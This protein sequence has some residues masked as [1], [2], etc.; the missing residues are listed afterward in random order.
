MTGKRSSHIPITQLLVLAL[1]A[2]AILPVACGTLEIGIETVPATGDVASAT[3]TPGKTPAPDDTDI[4][5][6]PA[7]TH[8]LIPPS[9]ELRVAFV[10]AT[11]HGNN[12]WLWT[13]TQG[14]AVPLTKDGGV[15][16]VRMS[17]DGEIVAFTRG[18][19]L[20]IVDSDAARERE[21]VSAE[22]FAATEGKDLALEVAL[23]RFDWIPGTHV[24]A[25][26]TRL[27]TE[28]GQVLNDDLHAFNVDTGQHTALLPPG[29]GGEFTYAPDGGQVAIVTP[30]SISL[31]DA[32]GANRREPLTYTPIATASEVQYY[33][34][35]AWAAD[36]SALR[37]VIPPVDPFAQPSADASVWHIATDGTP[38]RLLR[39]IPMAHTSWPAFS[40]DLRYVAHLYMEQSGPSPR[41]ELLITDLDLDAT[42]TYFPES[43]GDTEATPES[44]DA[45]VYTPMAGEVY[46]WWPGPQPARERRFAFLA[47][48]DPELPFQA[49]IGQLGGELVPVDG[50][51]QA[52]ID[53]RWV[54]AERYL[55]LAQ[56]PKGWDIKLGEFAVPGGGPITTVAGVVGS[57]PA[58]D[59]AAP[60]LDA[61]LSDATPAPAPFA[62]DDN[63][64][65]PFGLV[66]RNAEGLWH[67][68]ADGESV[69]L[70][71]R[72]GAAISPDATQVLY[73]EADDIWLAD[74]ATGERRNVTGT[75]DR[76]DCCP[77]WWPARPDVLLFSSRPPESTEPSYG[78]PTLVQL[79]GSDY[80][81]LDDDDNE[82][83]FTLPAPSPD[84][85]TVAYDRAGQA[86]LYRNDTGPE[87]F[88]LTR[89][90]LASDP[91]LRVVSPAWSPDGRRIAWVI[92]DCRRGECLYGVGV[93]DLELGNVLSLHPY[94][95]VGM[96]GQ[97]PGPAWSPDGQWL[98]F[99]AWATDSQD[100]GLW[101][102]R[103]AG[104]QE[105]HRL[106]AASRAGHNP[107]WSPDGSWLAFTSTT[108]GAGPGPWLADAETW[109]VHAP[110]LPLDA[111][112]VAWVNPPGN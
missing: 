22:A 74:V 101:V 17:D 35:P 88:D 109:S 45:I 5:P 56:S 16:D 98:A 8:T 79:D 60:V 73:P 96:G 63:A 53:V 42:M 3:T 106:D 4:P 31:I 49:Q 112:P 41:S 27:R 77:R 57:R 68:N 95:P 51:V 29:Q 33:A 103:A 75:P 78:F 20:W 66:Y 6:S 54:D 26:N 43:D 111:S 39:N 34:R 76:A 80:R 67:V 38:A 104:S 58:Y 82:A 48:T 23:N 70:F 72:P 28:I 47:Q 36:A 1:L 86:W 32:D 59:F 44:E 99:T 81:V 65:I 55:Y 11:E 46:G 94:T 50:G 61:P 18:D 102:V 40:P 91:Q 110:D 100:G 97:P 30:G 105:E 37:V 7:P 64:P 87:P 90:G 84:G 13:E 9:T 15:G 62:D 14:E 85:Q 107:V 108:Q 12:V 10:N 24:L 21:L 52:I 89:Y 69:R 2:G 25:F 19:G 83:S 93:F 92:G 71:D